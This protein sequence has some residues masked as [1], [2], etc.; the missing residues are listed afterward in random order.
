MTDKTKQ[1]IQELVPEVMELKFGCEV[2]SEMNRWRV[3][4]KMN[5]QEGQM[6][7]SRIEL[8]SDEL[9]ATNCMYE[10]GDDRPW[11]ILGSPITLAVVLRTL[12]FVDVDKKYPMERYPLTK[13]VGMIVGLWNLTKDNY[14]DQ[15]EE[16]KAFIGQLLG[17]V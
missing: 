16:T 2:Q 4:S 11:K 5:Y 7:L 13:I 14:D 1:R 15:S 3:W 17:V 6:P 8:V 10:E 12:E 9:K